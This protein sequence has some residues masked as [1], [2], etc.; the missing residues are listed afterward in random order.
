M[1]LWYPKVTRGVQCFI[2]KG[3]SSANGSATLKG[4]PLNLSADDASANKNIWKGA[5]F[6]DYSTTISQANLCAASI[7]IQYV[8]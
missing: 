7:T 4:V 2:K 6:S 8:G 5:C 1:L 3:S